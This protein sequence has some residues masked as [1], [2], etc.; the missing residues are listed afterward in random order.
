[1][2]FAWGVAAVLWERGEG[3]VRENLLY[4]SDFFTFFEGRVL[5][6]GL[7]GF[8]CGGGPA[9]LVLALCVTRGLFPFLSCWHEWGTLVIH[10]V[11][12]E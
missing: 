8:W 10:W 6:G 7:T 12:R 9:A 2:R 3:R 4:Q 1:M 11:T 5:L